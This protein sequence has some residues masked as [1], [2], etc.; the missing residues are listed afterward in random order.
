M[1]G[2]TYFIDF[3]GPSGSSGDTERDR[4][5]LARSTG[6]ALRDEVREP[7]LEDRPRFFASGGLSARIGAAD[8]STVASGRE[9]SSAM[10]QSESRG[11]GSAGGLSTWAAD[12]EAAGSL[13]VQ[14][15]EHP[16]AACAAE[17]DAAFVFVGAA[18]HDRSL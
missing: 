10:F 14:L 6:D 17:A 8:S 11:S 5:S 7:H 15:L 18:F 1:M 2:G 3:T 4:T 9:V 13:P 16:A 12:Q